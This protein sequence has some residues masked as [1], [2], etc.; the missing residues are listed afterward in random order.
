MAK[1]GKKNGAKESR[2]TKAKAGRAKKGAAAPT[3]TMTAAP[4]P[5]Q[6]N[7]GVGLTSGSILKRLLNTVHQAQN[8][9]AEIAGDARQ[10]IG[11]AVADQYLNKDAFSMLRK[12]DKIS[13][14]KNGGLEQ[15]ASLW[16][17]LQAYVESS[18]LG[19][20]MN[21]VMALPFEQGDE[22]SEAAEGEEAGD[23]PQTEGETQDNEQPQ[24]DAS[25]DRVSRPTFGRSAAGAAVA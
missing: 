7:E 21:E 13:R 4:K 20:K 11:Q 10:K 25:D 3:E 19:D 14:K 2:T 18:G 9:S 8:E 23:D 24:G 5:R 6:M 16:A 17:T 22:Q 1:P 12:M 15:A